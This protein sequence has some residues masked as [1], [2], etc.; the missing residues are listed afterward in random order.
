M[1]RAESQRSPRLVP[2]ALGSERCIDSPFA[3]CVGGKEGPG[4]THPAGPT[5]WTSETATSDVFPREP[6]QKL[7]NCEQNTLDARLTRR[8][9]VRPD[10]GSIGV[11]ADARRQDGSRW[12]ARSVEAAPLPPRFTAG[13]PVTRAVTP[14]L[15]A[16]AT[17]PQRAKPAASQD[18]IGAQPAE[19]AA[20]ADPIGAQ[21]AE[22]AAS[23]YE[24][25]A[26]SRPWSRSRPRWTAAMNFVRLT[27]SVFRMSSA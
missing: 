9:P 12:R 1:A 2:A 20:S 7:P 8:L 10:G 14:A 25:S 13:S 6:E 15:P 22:P 24:T 21:P 4:R 18:A 5:D 27:S 11:R 17:G 26:S 3:G 16:P 19:P 23:A